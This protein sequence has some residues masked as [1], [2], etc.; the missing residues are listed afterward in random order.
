MEIQLILSILCVWHIKIGLKSKNWSESMIRGFWKSGVNLSCD[1]LTLDFWPLAHYPIVLQK[2]PNR[3]KGNCSFH[4]KLKKD[5]ALIST[6]L[7]SQLAI[8]DSSH[9]QG[10]YWGQSSTKNWNF[11]FISC[12]CKNSSFSECFK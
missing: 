12:L 2:I 1:P 6:Y 10:I 9:L 8:F 3:A 7:D 11:M 5:R 4:W